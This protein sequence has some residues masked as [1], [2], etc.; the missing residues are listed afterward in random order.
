MK[1]PENKIDLTSGAYDLCDYQSEEAVA[2][3]WEQWSVISDHEQRIKKLE[4]QLLELK[5]KIEHAN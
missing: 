3:I 4:I 2:F 5:K 1:R